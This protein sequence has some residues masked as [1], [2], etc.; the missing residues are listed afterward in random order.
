MKRVVCLVCLATALIASG[1]ESALTTTYQPLSGL[2]A[3]G[4][5]ITPVACH[6]WY[7]HSGMP[8]AIN[9]ISA[10][11]VPPTNNPEQAKQDLNQASVFGLKFT[12]TDPNEKK[13][14][15]LFDATG[16]RISEDCPEEYR[17]EVIRASLEC[18]RRCLPDYLMKTPLTF[19]SGDADKE[20]LGKMV[21]EFNAHD[22]T[23]VFFKPEE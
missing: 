13:M 15:L 12:A 17:D 21:Q 8:T 11:N 5:V 16:L 9:L 22:R 7:S 3:G 20:W 1:G 2:G 10:R 14:G 6:D 4:V 18:L 19:K 23:K